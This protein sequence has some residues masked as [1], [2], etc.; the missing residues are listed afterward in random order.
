[1]SASLALEENKGRALSKM[2]IEGKTPGSKR[3]NC[4][5]KEQ[6]ACWRYRSKDIR[7]H[8]VAVK[9]AVVKGI[10]HLTWVTAGQWQRGSSN[11]HSVRTMVEHWITWWLAL[12]WDVVLKVQTVEE[13]ES[14]SISFLLF[15][16]FSSDLLVCWSASALLRVMLTSESAQRTVRLQARKWRC[17]L[18]TST[19]PLSMNGVIRLA[20]LS[21]MHCVY[22]GQYVHCVYCV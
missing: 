8:Y 6:L 17:S 22:A 16:I 18:M 5:E 20:C 21:C 12:G 11:C 19:C 4:A 2:K 10:E 9:C 15:L 7:S 3:D 14:I 1:M 13:Q